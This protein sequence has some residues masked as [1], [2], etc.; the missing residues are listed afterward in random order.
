MQNFKLLQSVNNIGFGKFLGMSIKASQSK[1][2]KNITHK[3][4]TQVEFVCIDPR[5]QTRKVLP[6]QASENRH[7]CFTDSFLSHQPT[8]T[9]ITATLSTSPSTSHLSLNKIHK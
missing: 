2:K 5:I 3:R 7:I 6:V 9:S 1:K 4:G 8:G